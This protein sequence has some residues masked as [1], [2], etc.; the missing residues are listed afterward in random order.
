MNPDWVE[1]FHKQGTTIKRIGK[2][3]Y[4]YKA[5]SRYDKTKGY[6]VSIQKY[7][8]K[9]TENGVIEPEQILFTP[10]IDKI[11]IALNLVDNVSNDDIETLREISVLD[12]NGVLYIGKLKEN[13]LNILGKYFKIENNRIWRN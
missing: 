3:Y 12:I 11:L 8:G 4:L 2:N 13:E 7:I 5:T 1:K 10:G 9:I 6:P